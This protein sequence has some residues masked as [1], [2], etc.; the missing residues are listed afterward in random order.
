MNCV[1]IVLWVGIISVRGKECDNR[2]NARTSASCKPIDEDKNSL[3]DLSLTRKIRIEGI[4]CRNG[5]NGEAG[6]IM[7]HIGNLFC[8]LD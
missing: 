3:I 5:I 2:C 1:L 8:T 7:C 6:A 4:N